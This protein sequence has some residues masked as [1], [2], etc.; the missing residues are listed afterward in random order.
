MSLC[1]H[2]Q[3]W[4]QVVFVCVW[5]VF[6]DSDTVSILS[7]PS[8]L[9]T[10]PLC[11]VHNGIGGAEVSTGKRLAARPPS[12]QQQFLN[13]LLGHP[14]R[15]NIFN[16]WKCLCHQKK[17]HL[18]TRECPAGVTLRVGKASGP[19]I[20]WRKLLPSRCAKIFQP[21]TILLMEEIRRSPPGMYTTLQI[22]G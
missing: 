20:A 5:F 19:E 14:T 22:M 17:H 21:F 4:K 2:Q 9:S 6:C 7:Y 13:L 11:R 1:G 3:A 16:Q 8:S 18:D 10:S 15:N 12:N